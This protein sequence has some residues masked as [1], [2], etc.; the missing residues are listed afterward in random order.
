MTD[1]PNLT[2]IGAKIYYDKPIPYLDGKEFVKLLRKK[3]ISIKKFNE[4]FGS[5]TCFA[6]DNG[7]AGLYVYDVEAVLER[8]KTGRLIGTQKLWD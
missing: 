3:K 8:M 4:Y 7:N 6:L 5:Q 1:Y 2:Q